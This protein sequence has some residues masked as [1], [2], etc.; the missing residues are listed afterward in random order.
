VK[1]SSGLL[2]YEGLSSVL[3]ELELSDG[4]HRW[5]V[6]PDLLE[7]EIVIARPV[8]TRSAPRRCPQRCSRPPWWRALSTTARARAALLERQCNA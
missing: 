2:A 7:A 8:A 1:G 6:E 5:T 3:S 4:E